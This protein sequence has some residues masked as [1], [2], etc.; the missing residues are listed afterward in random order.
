MAA[1]QRRITTA[2]PFIST[3]DGSITLLKEGD[4]EGS[5]A[6]GGTCN[7]AQ[8]AA[9][10]VLAFMLASLGYILSGDSVR[11]LFWWAGLVAGATTGI[12]ATRTSVGTEEGD[13]SGFSLSSVEEP[14]L[15]LLPMTRLVCDT[16][17]SKYSICNTTTVVPVPH[18]EI[19]SLVPLVVFLLAQLWS[20]S[21]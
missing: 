1:Y 21:L 18:C 6:G 12:H 13:P 2:T 8:G 15:P 14:L 11:S 10:V 3:S 17:L 4:D 7:V 5:V 9:G 20:G 19:K 16:G